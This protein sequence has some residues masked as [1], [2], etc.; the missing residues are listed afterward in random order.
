MLNFYICCHWKRYL[1]DRALAVGLVQCLHL[2][3]GVGVHGF[4]KCLG[5]LWDEFYLKNSI[6]LF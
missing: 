2:R 4:S 1:G 3:L 6:G 5:L